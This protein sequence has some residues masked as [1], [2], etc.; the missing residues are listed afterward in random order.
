MGTY[1]DGQGHLVIDG[2]GGTG[3]LENTG[4]VVAGTEAMA[5]LG[6]DYTPVTPT[7]S[8]AEFVWRLGT[9]GSPPLGFKRD[10]NTQ[11]RF[12]WN[13]S[14]GV[15]A[16][17]F[18]LTPGNKYRVVL[19]WNKDGIDSAGNWP[20]ATAGD[21]CAVAVYDLATRTPVATM[22]YRNHANLAGTLNPE[23]GFEFRSTG[24]LQKFGISHLWLYWGSEGSRAMADLFGQRL[25]SP[26]NLGIILNHYWMLNLRSDAPLSASPG[27]DETYAL[28]DLGS[29]DQSGTP[30]KRD[31]SYTGTAPTWDSTQIPQTATEEE[32]TS[33]DMTAPVLRNASTL[34]TSMDKAARGCMRIKVGD[35][36]VGLALGPRTGGADIEA[37]IAAGYECVGMAGYGRTGVGNTRAVGV[38]MAAGL[39]ADVTTT[40]YCNGAHGTGGYGTNPGGSATRYGVSCGGIIEVKGT[41]AD[42]T[43]GPNNSIMTLTI[44]AAHGAQAKFATGDLLKMLPMVYIPNNIN[45]YTGVLRIVTSDG[46]GV[47]ETYDFDLSNAATGF[48]QFPYDGASAA[49]IEAGVGAIR[50][51]DHINAAKDYVS[52]GTQGTTRTIE[53]RLVGGLALNELVCIAIP[54]WYKCNPDGTFKLGPGKFIVANDADNSRGWNDVKDSQLPVTDGQKY[55]TDE[56]LQRYWSLLIPDF[57]MDVVVDIDLNTENRSE[58]AAIGNMTDAVARI[59]STLNAIG[60]KGRQSC[61]IYAQFMHQIVKTTVW[62][63]RG[64]SIDYANAAEAVSDADPD[65]VWCYNRLRATKGFLGCTMEDAT[66]FTELGLGESIEAAA[67]ADVFALLGTGDW[68]DSGPLHLSDDGAALGFQ[69]D[70]YTRAATFPYLDDGGRLRGRG[71][72][73]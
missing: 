57:S 67:D 72:T 6:F 2:P 28:K 5:F 61:G 48:R 27:A 14:V 55:R 33:Y 58:S 50:V 24:G 18:S 43:L 1:Q 69:A 21:Q 70:L 56:Q 7:V 59:R 42:R 25:R 12:V 29:G 36:F 46:A 52:L 35:S 34:R 8:A 64:K 44:Q 19:G 10:N 3:R 32:I 47:V 54:P 68:L 39:G 51:S 16:R 65:N 4:L 15:T 30:V 20:G 22:V 66:A 62:R 45:R 41:G 71:R 11:H 17:T 73:R 23:T 40:W 60:I 38:S 13:T 26:L 37:M 53:Y 9:S 63:D 31:L 49:D